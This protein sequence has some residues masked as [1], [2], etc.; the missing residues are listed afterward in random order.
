MLGKTIRIFILLLVVISVPEAIAF[1][2]DSTKSLVLKNIVSQES[3][4][5]LQRD[6]SAEVLWDAFMT[7]KKANSGDPVAQHELGLR[8]LIGKDFSPDT[9]KAAYWINKAAEQHLLTA[10]YNL[11]LL[12]NNGWGIEWN[13]FEAYKHFRSAAQHGLVEAEYI[14]GLL[15]TD[16]LVVEKNYDEA[17]RWIKMAADSGFTPAEEVLKEFTARGIPAKINSLKKDSIDRKRFTQRKTFSNQKSSIR[18][19]F[20][21]FGTDSIPDPDNKTLLKDAVLEMN[22][23]RKNIPQSVDSITSADTLNE[24]VMRSFHDAAEAGS[25]EALTIIGRLYEQGIGVK[26]D[27]IQA[28]VYYIRAIRFDSPWSPMLLWNMM[29]K[30][31]YFLQLKKHIDE[32]DPPAKFV[33]SGLIDIGFDH[34][35]TDAQALALIEDASEQDYPEAI[36]QLGVCYSMGRWVQQD[37]EKAVELFQQAEKL[38]SRE[39]KIRICTIEL[40]NDAQ[41]QKKK[42]DIVEAL[43]LYISDGSVLAETALGFCYQEGIGVQ[44]AK[45]EAVRWYRRAAQRGSK[46]A[47]EALRKLYDDIRPD[48]PEFQIDE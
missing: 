12:L 40:K 10:Q 14:Y 28:S 39:A 36:V 25:P 19:I 1:G 31:N 38:G 13:P 17:Y 33:W 42:N 6:N 37:R 4:F 43:R 35:L 48:D 23:R 7:V 44:V 15:R 20:L 26:M 32:G 3:L 47:Y 41:I 46:S 8:Y 5:R 11:G 18:P 30:E 29:R 2:S 16:N 9:E 21:D 22:N 45:S 24:N 27:I 34:Q